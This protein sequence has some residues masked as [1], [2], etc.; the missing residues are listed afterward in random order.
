MDKILARAQGG[1]PGR[2]ARLDRVHDALMIVGLLA[3][4]Q[5]AGVTIFA[6]GGVQTLTCASV[7]LAFAGSVAILGVFAERLV[8]EQRMLARRFDQ[9]LS[10]VGTQ[11]SDE[12]R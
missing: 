1:S 9:S 12:R 11:A 7:I 10:W 6:R 2:T 8:S 4:G 5:V 3:V